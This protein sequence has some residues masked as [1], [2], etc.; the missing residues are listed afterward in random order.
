MPSALTCLLLIVNLKA[1][2]EDLPKTIQFNRDIRPILSDNCFAC[3]GPDKNQ[4]KA[5]LRL[6]VQEGLFSE[7]KGIRPITPGKPQ[8]SEIYR[9]INSHDPDEAMPQSKS[10]KTL[11]PHQIALIRRWIEQG[12]KWEGHWAYIPPVRSAPPAV[13]QNAWLKNSID[14]FVLARLEKEGLSPSVEAD[15]RTLI[16]R[17]SFDL[18]GLPPTPEDVDSFVRDRNARSY[19]QLVDRLLASSHFGERMAITWLDQVRYA[20]TDGFHADNYR[21][22]YPFRDYVINA[23]NTNMPFDQFTREQIA[24]D[25]MPNATLSQKVASTCNRLNR[26]TEEGGSQPKEYLAKYAADRVRTV[27]TTWMAGTLGCAECHDHKFDPYT[28]KD[29]YSFEAFFADIKEQGVGKPEGMPV[30]SGE[31]TARLKALDDEAARWQT[32]LDTAT[33]ELEAAQVNWEQEL[34]KQPHP[35]LG[36][37]YAAGPF[38]GGTFDAVFKKAFAPEKEVD[39][40][41]EFAKEKLKWVKHA[42]WADGTVH[43]LAGNPQAATYLY[44]LITADADQ[45]LGLS[46]GSDD[47]IKAWLNGK[48]VLS[49]KIDRGVAPDQEKATVQLHKGEN[50]LLLKIVNNAGGAGF[51]FKA[52]SALPT[53]VITILKVSPGERSAAQKAELAKYYRTIAPLLEPARGSLM[54]VR[55][56][57]TELTGSIPTTLATVAVEPRVMRVLPRGNWMS[58]A[59]EIVLPAAPAFLTEPRGESESKRKTRLDLA[60]WVVSPENP[61]T[62]RVF[63]NRLWKM[64]YG[65]GLSKTLDDFGSRGEWPTH[66]ELLDWLAVEFRESG[67]DVK[68]MVKLMVISATY[69]QSSLTSDK[70]R[71]R[72]PFNRLLARQSSF[73]LDAEMV[74]DNALAVSGLLADQIG[75]PSVKPYQPVGYWDQLNF[76]K[77]TYT[78]DHGAAQYRRGLYSFWCRTFLQPSMLAFDAPSREEC[79]VERVNSNTPLQALALLNDPTF[80]ECARVLAEHVLRDGGKNPQERINWIY[81]RALARTPNKDEYKLLSDLYTRQIERYTKNANNAEQLTSAGEY[82]APKDLNI[83]E[84][85]AW[86]SISRVVLNLHETVTRY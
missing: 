77:R 10:G 86:T 74:R 45:N 83:I 50:R 42:E 58:D 68:H 38:T 6:D 82:Q 25:L 69:R 49:N 19:E 31:Q 51:Y 5:N 66:P 27:A 33:P 62:A 47:A 24:G 59:G 57:R 79:T 20:D 40:A 61:L 84:L 78:N 54:G 55:N 15:R 12:A 2:A 28:T 70:L 39:L 72:D 4:R 81:K 76:P 11:S 60:N 44:R 14:S 30:P 22:V 32:V 85:A 29:F 52:G 65:T 37:W 3:H 26:T 63:V 53:A 46:L 71:E 21:S 7:I 36:D 56:Q 17:L 35:K 64:F 67:W 23:F 13:K 8:E 75:G 1:S 73:R 41:K 18:T 48:E 80:V 43:D 34:D 16:R 9:R